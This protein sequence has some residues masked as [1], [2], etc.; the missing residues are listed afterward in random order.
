MGK[1]VQK[2]NERWAGERRR[3]ELHRERV[4]EGDRERG[5]IQFD[6]LFCSAFNFKHQRLKLLGNYKASNIELLNTMNN[7][8]KC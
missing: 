1:Y 8:K 5:C 3:R 6:E 4:G 7:T 2:D